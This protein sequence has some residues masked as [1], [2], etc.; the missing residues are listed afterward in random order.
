MTGAIAHMNL[1]RL[2]HPAGDPRVAPFIDAIATVNGIAER[3][4][5]FIWRLTAPVTRTDTSGVFEQI[6]EDPLIAASLSV[7]ASPQALQDFVMKTL[8]GAFLKRR[9][10]WFEPLSGPV[11]VIW[12]VAPTA[13]PTMAEAR[14]KLAQLEATGPTAEVYDFAY[15]AGMRS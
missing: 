5:G 10:E 2:R 11:Y 7:W 8:H 13:R 4:P 12:P 1:A 15:A 14:A 3:S 6:D 9:A